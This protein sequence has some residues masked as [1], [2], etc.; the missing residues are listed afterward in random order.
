[1]HDD[2]TTVPVPDRDAPGAA[3]LVA[4]CPD[5][6]VLLDDE[7]RFR[8]LNPAAA[9]LLGRP[10]D[11]LL[12]TPAPFV[13]GPAGPSGTRILR[14]PGPDGPGRELRY[15]I[16]PD[17]TGG[18]AVW[19]GDVTDRLARQERLT[20]IVRAAAGVAEAGSLTSTLDAIAREI[21]G[22][23][24]IAAAQ[25]LAVDDPAAD[26]QVLGMAGF[27]SAPDFVRRLRSCRERGAD[28]R[29]L[30]AHARGEP[31]VVP[32][33]RAAI[34]SDPAWEPLHE[35]MG[36][37]DWDGFVAMPMV[38]RGTTVGVIN[39]YYQPDEAPDPSSLAFLEAMAAHAAVAVDTARLVARSRS[40][41]RTAERRRL[42]RDLHD[43]VV[44]Q[45]FSIRMQVS[46]LQGQL[47]RSDPDPSRVLGAAT[48]L[49]E[50]SADALDDLRLLVRE[51]HPAAPRGGDLVEAVR[52]HASEVQSRTGLRVDVLAP[53]DPRLGP[54]VAD[55][56]YRT[57]REALH[58]AVKH[59]GADTVRV[60]IER[61]DGDLVVE[62]ADDGTGIR[63]ADPLTGVPGGIGLVSMRERAERW[64][65]TCSAGPRP[66]GGWTVRTVLPVAGLHGEGA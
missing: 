31:V 28:I 37:P 40:E 7:G 62:I 5:G 39:A 22:T 32:H 20:A 49:S 65:G 43:S 48:E 1:M 51:M 36:R 63:P 3:A 57:V 59:A 18:W 52:T 45:L 55:D 30:E 9:A 26:L 66:D 35:I 23:A 8:S 24:H 6:L 42:A 54:G 10:A 19:F 38:V 56:L 41:A 60:R 34:L 12:G 16:A 46:A 2:V 33:R 50:M 44:Q 64:G 13:P 21:I 25:I 11:E 29:F 58:N 47:D 4:V 27:G 14:R 15:R 53:V 61:S 17:G